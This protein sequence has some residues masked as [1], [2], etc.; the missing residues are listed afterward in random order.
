MSILR[1]LNTGATGLSANADALGVVADNIANTNTIG[2]KR[3]RANFEDLVASAGRSELNEIGA[4]SRVGNVQAM[5]KQG[6]LLSTEAAMD[7]ALQGEGFFMVNGTAQGSSGNFYTRAGQFYLDKDGYIVNV[8]NLKMQGYAADA[9]GTILGKLD[10]LRISTTTLPA[11]ASSTANIGVNLDANSPII[12]AFDPANPGTTSNYSSSVTVYDSLGNSHQ[13]T[14][15]Y[16][17]TAIDTW[18]FNS[19]VDGSEVTGGVAGEPFLPADGTGVMT[20]DANGGLTAVNGVAV[21]D[22]AFA[23]VPSTWDFIGAIPGQ[24]IGFTFLPDSTT[25]FA[26]PSTQNTITQDG[27]AAGNVTSLDISATGVISGKFTNG[28]RRALG[29]VAVASFKAVDGLRRAGNG[30]WEQTDE[31]GE[32]LLGAGSTGGRGAIV[33]GSLEQSNVDIGREFVDL[34]AFQRG[35]QANSKIIQTSDEMYGELVNMKR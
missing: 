3:A 25:S 30:L 33:S 19:V 1:N 26:S 17:R 28:Q 14:T 2:F 7:L 18:A 34:I 12:A 23:P 20:F 32:P 24:S 10:D 29:Q 35:F 5:W 8:D 4:G 11:T 22:P 9:R 21:D 6:A 31:S 13:I 16:T 27:F 15:Y